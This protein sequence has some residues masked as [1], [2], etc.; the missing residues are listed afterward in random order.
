MIEPLARKLLL[1][2][3]DAADWQM[4]HPLLDAGRLPHLQRLT[5]TGVM[6]NLISLQPMLSPILWT[7]IATGKRAYQHGV[8]GFVEPTPDGAALRPTSSSTRKCKA[9]WNILAEAGK[10]CQAIGWYA[11][12]PAE[13]INGACVSHQ[14]PVAP[15]SAS[16][17]DW[18]AQPNSVHPVE[19]AEQ[20]TDLRL[21]P[22]EVT[23]QML[24][25]FIPEAGQL[26]QR[27]PEVRRLLNSF[28]RRLAECVSL[29]AVTTALMAEVPWDFCTAYYEAI[30]HI[31]HDFMAY[32]PPRMEHI[33]P[34]LFAAFRGVMDATY[35]L[36]DQMLGRLVELAGPEAHVMIVSDHGFLSGGRRPTGVVDPAQWHR[37][38]GVFVC[39][40]PGIRQDAI[41]HGATLLDIAPTILT[42]F[43]LPV[44]RDM[45]GKVLVNA[46]EQM[47][48]IE[49]IDSW[50][51]AA[52]IEPDGSTERIADDPEAAAAALEQLVELGYIEAPGEDVQ[53]DIA[54]ARAEQKFNLACTY[55]DGKQPARALAVAEE[56]G[57]QFPEEPRYAVLAGQAAISAGDAAALERAITNSEKLKPDHKQMLVFRAF[58]CWLKDDMDGALRYFQEAAANGP[59]DPWLLCR[60]GRA[61]L[62][63]QRWADAEGAFREAL[64]L[65]PD[66][67]E[68][69]YGLSIALPRQGRLEE[70]VE[71]GLKAISLF[72]DFPLAHFQ[73]GAVLSRLG[74]YER[75]L[76]A[77][78]ICL[79]IRPDFAAAHEY[80]SRIARLLG[81]MEVAENHRQRA[82]A[83][84]EQALPQPVLD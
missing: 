41:L 62:R 4:I 57:A 81:K 39:A 11:S 1:V 7:S 30:D 53:R 35:E 25:Q 70:G 38:F 67:P 48:E 49:R 3:W 47:P 65:D 61:L 43:G 27:D 64:A 36:H 68:V 77:F 72:H 9:I 46:F 22:R 28:A 13:A 32:H 66:N 29:H 71:C 58:H 60:V 12:H 31:G 80:V 75:A 79:A 82:A 24:S 8:H 51:G 42:L 54:R 78:E 16:P 84:V 59:R 52:A 21:H 55:I 69:Y 37:N 17:E 45:E 50:E 56:L 83:I 5:E 63:L 73:L 19:L 33:R 2:G 26:D 40:G 74:W 6:G 20:L 10:R 15:A 14:F 76:Q 44:G 34:D 23:G 18:P